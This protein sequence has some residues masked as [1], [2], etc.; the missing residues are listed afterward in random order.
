MQGGRPGNLQ[1]ISKILNGLEIDK[2]IEMCKGNTLAV[3]NLHHV[4]IN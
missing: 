3:S 2:G 4:V 1:M